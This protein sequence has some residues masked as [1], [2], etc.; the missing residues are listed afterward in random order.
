MVF[1]CISDAQFICMD[2]FTNFIHHARGLT[3][4]SLNLIDMTWV[5]WQP[6]KTKKGGEILKSYRHVMG[7]LATFE[8]K[9]GEDNTQT[10]GITFL[11]L[12]AWYWGARTQFRIY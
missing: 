1:V 11:T 12:L 9:Q 4:L 8:T 3:G 10:F 5:S 2:D 7:L 6:L